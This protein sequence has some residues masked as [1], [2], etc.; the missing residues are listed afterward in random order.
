MQLHTCLEPL[1]LK[2]ISSKY[3]KIGVINKYNHPLS[4]PE[5]EQKVKDIDV[6]ILY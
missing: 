2:I 4:C 1:L 5:F 6:A 3:Y